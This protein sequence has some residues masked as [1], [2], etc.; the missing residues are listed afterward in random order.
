MSTA[1]DHRLIPLGG[2]P[3]YAVLFEGTEDA[4]PHL[5]LVA[6][7][8]LVGAPGTIPH[9]LDREVVAA[10]PGLWYC[11][12]LPNTFLELIDIP[13]S[14]LAVSQSLDLGHHIL[15]MPIAAFTEEY[16]GPL[17]RQGVPVL[18]VCPDELLAETTER[19]AQLDFRLS[20][21]PY[22]RL[23]SG[24]IEEHWRAT[25]ELVDTERPY[26]GRVP[27]LSRRLE[28]A[29]ADLPR[30]WLARQLDDPEEIRAETDSSEQDEVIYRALDA[31]TILGVV[32]RMVQ[33]GDDFEPNNAVLAEERFRRRFPVTI[34]SPG[35]APSY[36]NRAYDLEL[37][38]E[39]NRDQSTAAA[40]TWTTAT[41]RWSDAS[42]ELSAIRFL[43]THRAMA[44]S[45]IGITLPPIGSRA[46]GVLAQLETLMQ[47]LSPTGRAVA[48]LLDRLAASTEHLWTPA[49]TATV[50]RAS[51]LT[52]HSNFPIGL[53]RL[54]GDSAPIA[55][56]VPVSYR[57]LLPLTRAVQ[58]ELTYVPR[59]DLSERVK[60]LVA[61]C[62][63]DSD[64]VGAPSRLGWATAL[65]MLASDA[66]D[67][68]AADLVETSSAEGLRAAIAASRPHILIISAHGKFAG[69]AA[70][71]VIGG[72]VVFGPELGSLPPVVILSAC[73]TAPRGAGIVSVVDLLLRQGA[74]AVLGT[75][76]PVDVRRNTILTARFLVNIA[77]V[78]A[79]R[80][81]SGDNLLEVW[82]HV[83]SGNAVNDILSGN[84]RLEAW[85]ASQGPGGRSVLEEFMLERSTGRLS[86][87]DIYSATET[88]LGE[89]ADDMGLGDRVRN[90]FRNPGYVPESLFYAFAG[91]PDRIHLRSRPD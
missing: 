80:G 20:P 38:T 37:R 30:R 7:P 76:V 72:R 28:F 41:E 39:R 27:R 45:G 79:G 9:G 64:P 86:A 88:V 40:D 91:S 54:P 77:E 58:A 25:Y 31:Q 13:P 15:L 42:A 81:N 5:P 83:Q 85:G 84:P 78:L 87:G 56:R 90:W 75:Q 66:G 34:A 55:A 29:A 60:V 33:E 68:I 12:H 73:H 65:A 50:A 82:R 59:I 52:V 14:R 4:A 23:S 61:E 2:A 57:P 24:S 47:T 49:V 69:N 53:L 8:Y 19:C 10:L 46:F 35:V 89:I 63:P 74:I 36:V 16:V 70:G 43:A 18:A 11:L 21:T 17:L 67:R 62:I 3:I 22:S 48:R 6:A 51:S 71:L 44:H 26:L 32:A 1:S